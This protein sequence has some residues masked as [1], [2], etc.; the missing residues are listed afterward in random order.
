MNNAAQIRQ[1][2]NEAIK[3]GC[4]GHCV[5]R[6]KQA[7]TLLPCP[8]CNSTGVVCPKK[9]ELNCGKDFHPCAKINCPNMNCL[10]FFQTFIPCPD[11]QGNQ[12]EKD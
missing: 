5:D 4:S 3:Q 1:L 2:L 8:T 6:L 10:Y 11:C 7:L 12:H 9:N